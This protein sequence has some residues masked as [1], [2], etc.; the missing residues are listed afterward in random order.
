MRCV[1]LGGMCTRRYQL[2]VQTDKVKENKEKIKLNKT[3]P[4]LIATVV[5]ILDNDQLKSAG[6]EEEEEEEETDEA[7][8]ETVSTAGSKSAVIKTT[9]RQTVYLPVIG[10]VD[11]DQLSPGDTV[12]VNKDSFLILE[13]LPDEYD[14]R[15][16]AMEVDE[17]P[18]EEFSD[19]GGCD[20]Q[21]Q[22]LLEAV[23]MP[24]KE[25]H[26]F[27]ALG[28]QAPKGVLLWGPPGT[29]KTLLARAWCVR[30]CLRSRAC[31]MP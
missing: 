6:G 21:I 8:G 31:A 23:V 4:Y 20:K 28:I 5:E 1:R 16:K 22:E 17:R 24:M 3:L 29:G 7:T 11:A 15:V 26:L 9:T 2:R 25:A 10:L 19:I 13:K 18:T 14:S 12:G 30:V 27:K